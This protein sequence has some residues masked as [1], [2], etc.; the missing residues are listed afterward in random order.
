VNEK[1]TRVIRAIRLIRKGVIDRAGQALD[2]KGL[3]DL[4]NPEILA[5]LQSK[6]P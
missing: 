6:H 5:Q 3:G 1:E 4:S 2:N